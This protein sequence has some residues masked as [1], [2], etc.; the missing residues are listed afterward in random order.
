MGCL[1]K[2]RE[3]LGSGRGARVSVGSAVGVWS[4]FIL[5]QTAIVNEAN[6][7]YPIPK[8]FD[9]GARCKSERR[10][11]ALEVGLTPVKGVNWVCT[12]LSE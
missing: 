5:E 7:G 10:A 3:I 4:D 8:V 6:N 9:K 1:C 2:H 12:W 11:W